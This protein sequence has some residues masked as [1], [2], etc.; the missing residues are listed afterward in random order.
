[1]PVLVD[2]RD[3]NNEGEMKSNG[4]NQCAHCRQDARREPMAS[5]KCIAQVTPSL[6]NLDGGDPREAKTVRKQERLGLTR[7]VH[8]NYPFMAFILP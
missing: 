5:L 2:L 8:G 4:G 6:C 7:L 1:M 3:R